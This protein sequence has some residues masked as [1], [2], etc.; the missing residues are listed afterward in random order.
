V[1]ENRTHRGGQPRG[2]R[3]I[4]LPRLLVALPLLLT[5]GCH[6]PGKPDPDERPVPPEFVLAFDALFKRNCAGCHGPDGTLGPAPPLNDPIFR[7][8]V[9]EKELEAVISKGRRSASGTGK[10]P[11][12]PMPAF[13]REQGGT[14]SPAQIQVLVYE[15]KGIRYRIERKGENYDARVEVVKDD[16]GKTPAWGVTPRPA[17]LDVSSMREAYL[18]PKTGDSKRGARVFGNAC[19]MCHGKAGKG[20]QVDGVELTIN[21][22]AFLALVS[23]KALRRIVITGRPDLGMPNYAEKGEGRMDDFKPLTAQDITDLSAYLASWRKET[24]PRGK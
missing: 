4:V 14:L 12:T 17:R 11:R 10:D 21:D 5:V 8:I 15:I 24:A 1:S 22:T 13:A 18:N 3:S 16:E 7:A 2:W 23:D 19:A 9:S 20:G 6:W